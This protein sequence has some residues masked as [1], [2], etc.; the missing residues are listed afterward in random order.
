MSDIVDFQETIGL[1]K[2]CYFSV[3][4]YFLFI[5]VVRSVVVLKKR[6][7]CH[8]KTS[9]KLLLVWVYTRKLSYAMLFD[10]GW[11]SFS[12]Q[13]FNHACD[14]KVYIGIGSLVTAFT[15]FSDVFVNL[16]QGWVTRGK[17][18]SEKL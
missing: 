11:H 13:K 2:L 5:L 17:K 18:I 10:A 8:S 4:K 9:N 7:K 12:K 15:V 16:Q 1:W 14:S 3:M 6:K